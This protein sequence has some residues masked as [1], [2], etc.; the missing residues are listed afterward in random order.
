MIHAQVTHI[1]R[2]PHT[3]S[4]VPWLPHPCPVH[5]VSLPRIKFNQS[6]T[7]GQRFACVSK[8][9]SYTRHLF[10]ARSC[11][12]S[13]H[14]EISFWS[15][16]CQMLTYE[17]RRLVTLTA[18]VRWRLVMLC[19]ALGS[20]E[21]VFRRLYWDLVIFFFCAILENCND[22][23]WISWEG[24]SL[25][26]CKIS[27]WWEWVSHFTHYSLLTEARKNNR[28][29]SKIACACLVCP[30]VCSWWMDLTIIIWVLLN[31]LFAYQI[32]GPRTANE[33]CNH[34]YCFA[35]R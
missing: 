32:F 30:A 26:V 10:T 12:A 25:H 24:I 9:D 4:T 8:H 29:E 20:W 28:R 27:A 35:V 6:T 11:Q 21:S 34:L 18:A 1:T 3:N 19:L 16:S 17:F 23:M 31:S 7:L 22:T 13:S 15:L 2:T 14:S 5:S 33:Q